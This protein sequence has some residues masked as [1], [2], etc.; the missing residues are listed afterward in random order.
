VCLSVTSLPVASFIS[1]LKL[2]YEQLYY[3]ILLI[4]DSWIFIKLLRSEVMALFAYHSRLH[5]CSDLSLV[6][7][8]TGA[9]DVVRKANC[10]IKTLTWDMSCKAASYFSLSA[11]RSPF[12][13]LRT[14]AQDG[15]SVLAC[16][17]YSM[18]VYV[19]AIYS[20]PSVRIII[21]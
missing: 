6:F 20:L 1:T 2:R 4:F 18:L 7:A 12:L 17:L 11:A 8:T 16:L 13:T 5:Y 21:I 14:H 10:W 3:G 19:V 15:F 9:F